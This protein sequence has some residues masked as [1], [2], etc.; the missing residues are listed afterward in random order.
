MSFKVRRWP[1]PV[2]ASLPLAL[3]LLLALHAW[4]IKTG[5]DL[6]VYLR[7][8]S[9][10]AAAQEMYVLSESSPFK[11]SPPVALLFAP[12][13]RLPQRLAYLLWVL[14]S[15]LAMVQFAKQEAGVRL[16]SSAGWRLVVLALVSPY[17]SQ[18]FFLGQ[19]DGMLVWIMGLS[20]AWVTRRPLRSGVLWAVVVAFKLPFLL[21]ALPALALGQWRRVAG[22]CLG[23][24]LVGLIGALGFGWPGV[25]DEFVAWRAMLAVS[26]TVSLTAPDNQS[27]SAILCSL[28]VHAEAQGVLLAVLMVTISVVLVVGAAG[29]SRAVARKDAAAAGRLASALTFFFVAFLSPLGWLSNFVAM[30]PVACGLLAL[31]HA[32]MARVGL[33]ALGAAMLL[34]FNLLGRTLYLKV[35]EL[36]LFGWA[37][38]MAAFCLAFASLQV[39]LRSP[40][41][42]GHR[43]SSSW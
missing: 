25:L 33:A 14:T 15:A 4:R 35:L 5:I 8:G 26:T 9:R 7:A 29:A 3:T 43:D 1:Q 17:L 30:V 19:C 11:Y 31:R 12:F 10:A 38:L 41:P 13:S 18:V 40:Q 27:L 16:L 21:F 2:I 32:Q 22:F 37:T 34:N 28:G 23:L 20:E 6:Q 42:G 39:A 24:V 36:R